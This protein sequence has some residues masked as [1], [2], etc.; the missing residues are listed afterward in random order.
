M[1][2][3]N[4]SPKSNFPFS[5]LLI[6]GA[7]F[8]ATAYLKHRSQ[9]QRI[10]ISEQALQGYMKKKHVKR[11]VLVSPSKQVK[12]FINKKALKSAAHQKLAL[13]AASNHNAHYCIEVQ[14]I[15]KFRER[16][17]GFQAKIKSDVEI[18]VE[19]QLDLFEDLAGWTSW[20][21]LLFLLFLLLRLATRGLMSNSS[22]S[23]G[24]FGIG[25]S[26]AILW[27]EE[28]KVGVTLKDVAG[29]EE[30]KEEVKEIIDCLK[31]PERAK[32]LGGR[33]PKGVLLVGQPGTGKTLLA[34]AV[35]GEAGVPFFSVSGSDFV[36]LFVGVG[37][38]RVADLFQEARKNAPCIIFIDEIDAIGGSRNSRRLGGSNEER[39]NTLN[40]LLTEMD[41]FNSEDNIVIIGATNRVEILDAALLRPGRFDRQITI[42]L[43][44][45]KDRE[46]I[47]RYHVKK[48][49]KISRNIDFAELSVQTSGSSGA[50]IANTCN[51]AALLA[52]RKGKKQIHMDDFQEALAR[53]TIGLEK[54][55][56]VIS[57]E[58]K[59]IVAW[60]EAGHAV[61]AWYLEH[62][63]PLVKVSIIPRGP[64]ALGYAQYLPKEQSLYQ[65]AQLYDRICVL[66][67]ARAAEELTFGEVSTGAADDLKRST[68]IAYNMIKKFGMDKSIGHLAFDET[69]EYY[70]TPPY[71]NATS[72][73]MDEAAQKIIKKQ[74]QRAKNILKSRKDELQAVAE[75]LLTKEVLM[76]KDVEKLIG[77]RPFGDEEEGL[78]SKTKLIGPAKKSTRKKR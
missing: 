46:A 64:S 61:A 60:H 47:F 23:G 44:G 17:D 32:S 5:Q 75:A 53:V 73:K 66:L 59:K 69:Q 31:S 72:E 18:V 7:L 20:L 24:I 76:T 51:E 52:A 2:N 78:P 6:L 54:K 71:S 25:K 48:K 9:E 56:K 4:T 21:L 39:E 34:K 67:A 50:D 38:S 70:L 27:G 42:G 28:D 29:M 16:F 45:I 22:S 57:P 1:K 49:L 77:K 15:E 26:K 41:G 55:T 36:E 35:A 13:K 8:S 37:A 40:K 33:I 43:P 19:P 74:Y 65:E 68:S 3:T 14:S 10:N 62:A 58:E 63:S 11:I 30:E 12:V